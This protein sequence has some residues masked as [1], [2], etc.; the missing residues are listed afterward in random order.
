MKIIQ[1]TVP[2]TPAWRAIILLNIGA[3]LSLAWQLALALTRANNGQLIAAAVIAAGDDEQKQKA[4]ETLAEVAA[5]G[6]GAS[7]VYPLLV[8]GDV[9]E[10]SAADLVRETG[11]DLLL[12]QAEV[13]SWHSLNRVSC[14]VAVVRG[15][16]YSQA[17]TEGG[18]EAPLSLRRILVPTS[19]GPNV[20]HALAL[21]SP[22]A[23]KSEITALYVVRS[24]EGAHGEAL[25]QSRLRQTVR[26]AGADQRIKTRLIQSDS[27]IE[28]IVEEA[29]QDYDLVVIG[30]TQESSID[31]ALFGDIP[32]AV[33]RDSKKPVVVVRQP[34][35][36]AGNLVR[37][38]AWS[39]RHLLPPLAA[40]DR[41]EAYVRIRRSTRPDTDY[42]IL[43]AL[44]AALA[45]MGLMLNSP[46]VVIGA[47]L[48]APLMSPIV[49]T[50]MAIILGDGRF[51]RLSLAAVIRGVVVALA[52]SFL[53]GFLRLQ[54][55]MT[56]E[57]LARTEPNLLDLGVA[58]FSGFAGAYALCRSE[59]AAALPGVAI[60]AALVPPLA[61]VG[62]LFAGGEVRLGLGALLLFSTNL[63]AISSAAVLVFLALGFRP[64][65]A[66]KSRQR[67]QLQSVRLAGLLLVVIALLLGTTT[68]RLLRETAVVN[69]THRLVRTGLEGTTAA[70]IVDVQID[71]LRA[72]TLQIDVTVRSPQT[73]PYP[74]VVELQRLLATE[75][76][77]EVALTLTVIPTTRLDPLSPPAAE[78]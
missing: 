25:G 71:N 47:M 12:L 16:R 36:A 42:Y 61:S 72:G 70:H 44:S 8:T 45:S 14:T 57:V 38:V 22:L 49:G 68:A 15:H 17:A 4:Q 26:F 41:A 20:A 1:G 9:Y 23:S 40:T 39:L 67:L 62:I 48:V 46:A 56:G 7:H 59:A 55:P 11:A 27:A 75:L 32:A 73:I 63:V 18:Q 60:A 65:A 3:P 2:T 43:M 28:G 31:R 52:V 51:L 24:S 29:S 33:V 30:A 19:G 74:M 69:N 58:L 6:R 66:K 54:E 53:S 76:Q 50:G 10:Q 37:Q 35:R 21:F 64:A 77:R 13:L 34:R 78:Q 5:A